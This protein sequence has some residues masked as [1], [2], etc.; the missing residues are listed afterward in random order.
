MSNKAKNLIVG[1]LIFIAVFYLV[2]YIL[3]NYMFNTPKKYSKPLECAG[4]HLGGVDSCKG[5]SSGA[6]FQNSGSYYR[7]ATGKPQQTFCADFLA[8]TDKLDSIPGS[9]CKP[10]KQED[11]LKYGG[12]QTWKCYT[13]DRM[14]GNGNTHYYLLAASSVDCQRGIFFSGSRYTP[15]EMKKEFSW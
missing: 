12:S 8:N 6:G 1:A 15:Q 10:W 9:S 7:I 4:G 13:C 11:C 3:F 2:P 14:A 5:Y